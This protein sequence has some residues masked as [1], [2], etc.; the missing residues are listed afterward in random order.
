MAAVAAS[1]IYT[2]IYN[3]TDG[4]VLIVVLFHAASNVL[5]TA[6]LVDPFEDHVAR[7]F[8]IYVALMVLV[9]TAVTGTATLSRTRGK[10][11]DVP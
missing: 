1:V 7:P 8:L 2:W 6:F 11:V 4:S 5:L 10:Q 3:G 9:V